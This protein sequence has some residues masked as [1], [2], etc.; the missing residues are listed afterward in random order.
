MENHGECEEE[1]Q[2][3][4]IKC[5]Q[6]W[7]TGT[8]PEFCGQHARPTEE[9]TSPAKEVISNKH[10]ELGLPNGKSREIA[11]LMKHKSPVF[12]RHAGKEGRLEKSEKVSSPIQY[13]RHQ[14]EWCAIT[15]NDNS[16]S[17]SSTGSMVESWT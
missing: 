10:S 1:S 7:R 4:S 5:H 15:V 2:G 12:R 9:R 3:I 14:E 17:L 16:T 8:P 13:G 6:E 11:D